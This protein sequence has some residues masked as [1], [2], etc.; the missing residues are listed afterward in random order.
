MFEIIFLIFLCGY[1]IQSVLFIIGTNKSFP[2]IKDEELPSAAVIVAV[3]NE[4]AN[5]TR[6]LEALDKLEYPD[7]KLEVIISDGHSTDSTVQ[8]VDDFIKE[9]QRFKG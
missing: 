8:I 7:G 6:C 9:R 5:I 2:K 4:E 1:F 3:R